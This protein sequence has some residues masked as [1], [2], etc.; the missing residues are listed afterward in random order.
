MEIDGQALHESLPRGQSDCSLQLKGQV[1]VARMPNGE[2]LKLPLHEAELQ[3]GGV[4]GSEWVFSST[5]AG[6]PTFITKN[7]DLYR[8]AML[9][10]PR[11][12]VGGAQ[13]RRSQAGRLSTF[14]KVVLG[15]VA[16]LL[17][18]LIGALLLVG[19][20][21]RVALRFVPRSS[22]IRIG[23]TAYPH[24]IRQI[25]WGDGAIEQADIREPV[26]SVLERVTA[27]LPPP[28]FNF[29]VTVCRSP[30]PN[31][32]A[33]PGGE[34]LVT[35]GLLAS[36][37]SADEL[38]AVLAHEVNHILRRHTMELTIKSSGLRFLVHMASGGHLA[39]GMAGSVWG[40][41]TLMEKA[42]DKESEADRLAVR[43][44]VDAGVDPRAML[45]L[46]GRLAAAEPRLPEDCANTRSGKFFKKLRSHPQLA[47]RGLDV[48]NE[49]AKTPAPVIVPF[50]I[51]YP[52][53]VTAVLAHEAT[54]RPKRPDRD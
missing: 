3:R 16:A 52:A 41:V 8:A 10:W 40:A 34:I 54:A 27:A 18:S 19:P 48:E 1:L 9:V 4:G 53:L 13:A 12:R 22:D 35:T 15:V 7:G 24:A 23:Q 49:I 20:L 44:L 6:G 50:D 25:G 21:A 26:Q 46:F 33:L 11:A 5:T 39:V 2:I 31:A 28:P 38:A 47:Q 42:R 17:L 32:F 45:D 43:L 51:D 14:Q 30:L 36:L 37:A 29:R